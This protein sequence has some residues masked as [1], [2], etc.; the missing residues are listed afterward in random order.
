MPAFEAGRASHYFL[1]EFGHSSAGNRQRGMVLNK[2][3]FFKFGVSVFSCL[4]YVN[5]NAASCGPV[6]PGGVMDAQCKVKTAPPPI[7]YFRK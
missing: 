3:L 2:K 4:I 1:T 7:S 6:P 5:V